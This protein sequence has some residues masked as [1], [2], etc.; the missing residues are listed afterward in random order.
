MTYVTNRSIYIPQAVNNKTNM[1]CISTNNTVWTMSIL[2]NIITTI[3]TNADK[4]GISCNL[5]TYTVPHNQ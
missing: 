4:Q 5:L 1:T 3:G 2:E